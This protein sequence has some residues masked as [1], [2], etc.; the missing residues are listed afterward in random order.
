MVEVT[1]LQDSY[2]R[3]ICIFAV[4]YCI[5]S[6]GLF[7]SHS[8]LNGTICCIIWS[9]LKL[10]RAVRLWPSKCLEVMVSCMLSVTPLCNF[11]HVLLVWLICFGSF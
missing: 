9:Q 2:V 11:P 3:D 10:K 6:F 5:W 8:F 4:L 7:A 1:G